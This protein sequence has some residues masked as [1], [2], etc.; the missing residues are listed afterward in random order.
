MQTYERL[1]HTV[2]ECKYHVVFIP[3]CRRKALYAQLR[4]ALG[5]VFRDLAKQ[6]ECKVEEGN[7]MPDHVHHVVVGAAEVFG[8]ERDGVHQG[9]KR[10]PSGAGGEE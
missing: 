5:A 6:K 3:K 2:W 7:L 10:D 8:G 9:E 4:R 1:K